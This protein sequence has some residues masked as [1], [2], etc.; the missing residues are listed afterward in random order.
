MLLIRSFH[1]SLK[2]KPVRSLIISRF[3]SNTS[4]DIM[5]NSYKVKLSEKLSSLVRPAHYKLLLNPNLKTGTFSGEVEINVVVKETRN[6]IALHSK[7]LEVN[8]VKVNKNRE[9]V[10]VSKFLEVTS[11]EQLLIQ[12]DNNLPPGNYDISIKFNGNLT[13]NI[14]GFYLSHLKDKRYYSHCDRKFLF[15]SCVYARVNKLFFTVQ[16]LL[17]SSSQ[18]MLDKLSPVSMSQNTKQH[19][20]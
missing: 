5:E 7:F 12:F 6:F 4:I 3:I 8:D 13:R 2:L 14:V 17:V 10:S 1:G 18:L 11:L 9:E 15:E 20:T 19:M 16:W